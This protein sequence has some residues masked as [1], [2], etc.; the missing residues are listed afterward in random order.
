[1]AFFRVKR[2]EAF[3]IIPAAIPKAAVTDSV[4]VPKK[5]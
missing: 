5:F 3:A 4:T 1:L 2:H